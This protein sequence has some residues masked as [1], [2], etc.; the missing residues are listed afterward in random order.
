MNKK[1]KL[2]LIKSINTL[3]CMLLEHTPPEVKYSE[4][5]Y[6]VGIIMEALTKLKTIVNDTK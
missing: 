2:K 1:E 4:N 6:R 5:N 3:V